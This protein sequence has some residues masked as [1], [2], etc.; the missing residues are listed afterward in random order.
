[1]GEK[2]ELRPEIEAFA[3]MM[4]RVLRDNEHKGGWSKCEPFWLLRRLFQE[5]DELTLAI[6][7]HLG[8]TLFPPR[9]LDSA[10]RKHELAR[11]A[12]DVANFA[13]MIADVCGALKPN[14]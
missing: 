12:A 6:S 5:T 3:Q 8:R 4:E 1:M 13:M 10:P 14:T 2:L 9:S 11:E 7:E